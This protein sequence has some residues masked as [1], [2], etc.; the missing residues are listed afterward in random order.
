MFP[1]PRGRVTQLKP[2]QQGL[3]WNDYNQGEAA[4]KAERVGKKYP[5][6]PVLQSSASA[7][8]S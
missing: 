7:S 5:A 2:E 8:Y 1:E 4:A 6:F 3:I